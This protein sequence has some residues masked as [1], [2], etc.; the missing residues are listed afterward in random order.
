MTYDVSNILYMN[1]L[2][3]YYLSILIVHVQYADLNKVL[4]QLATVVY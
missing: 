2:Y 4:L 1:M 3:I